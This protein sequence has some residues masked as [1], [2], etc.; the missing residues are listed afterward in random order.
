MSSAGHRSEEPAARVDIGRISHIVLHVTRTAAENR[1]TM[2]LPTRVTT[3]FVAETTAAEVIAGIDLSGKR[4]IVTGGASGIG[5]ESA[6]ALASAGAE[7]TLAVRN[8]EEGQ[9]AGVQSVEDGEHTLRRGGRQA[10]GSR[11]NHGE[12]TDARPYPHQPDALPGHATGG[13]ARVPVDKPSIAY[14]TVEQGA[15]TSVRLAACSPAK[16]TVELPSASPHQ[17]VTRSAPWGSLT[18]PAAG[19]S[20][21]RPAFR[22]GSGV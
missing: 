7:V 6:R 2:P 20:V 22:E 8:V 16:L 4:A 5:L 13:A 15:S 12:C 9:E 17:S 14:K 21:N 11:R 19:A 1:M 10:M 3:P 18:T